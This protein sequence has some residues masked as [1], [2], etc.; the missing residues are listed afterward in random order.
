MHYNKRNSMNSMDF[1]IDTQKSFLNLFYNRQI[2]ESN[3]Q[4]KFHL[5]SKR[6]TVTYSL[7]IRLRWKVG[8]GPP[9]LSMRI[10]SRDS[11]EQFFIMKCRILMH[12]VSVTGKKLPLWPFSES[13]ELFISTNCHLNWLNCLFSIFKFWL[14][15]ERPIH[16]C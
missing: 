2:V 7:G 10:S 15:V 11:R 4:T 13:Q 9:S 12:T 16:A 6:T 14:H 5:N 3:S 8:T 1:L